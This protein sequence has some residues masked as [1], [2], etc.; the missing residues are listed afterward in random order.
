MPNENGNLVQIKNASP[1][2]SDAPK[3]MDVE[4]ARKK[5]DG[6]R[7]PR[8]WR[9]LEELSGDPSFNAMIE[10]EF[11]RYV[12]EWTDGVSRR[13][14]LKLSAASLAIAGLS[15]CT[16]QPEEAI[17]PYVQQPEELIPGKPMYFA[18]ARPSLF[19]AAPLLVRSN[20]YHPTNIQGNPD[21]PVSKGATDVF[22]IGS[23][24]DLYDP[25]RAQA[26]FYNGGLV[27]RKNQMPGE[28]AWGEVV[29]DIKEAVA[30][31]R[32]SGGAGIRFLT[33][34]VTSPSL[35]A[36]IRTVMQTLPQAKWYQ[37]EP[38][39]RDNARAGQQMAF[40]S[41]VEPQY[42]LQKADVI[43][44]LD[45]DFLSGPTFPGFHQLAREF[46]S[47][48]KIEAPE[49]ATM[50][51][52]YVVESQTTTTGGK[53]DH[54]L[55][56]KPSQVEQF[57]AALASRVGVSGVSGN[58]D[59][60]AAK[61]LDTLVKD[62]NESRGKCVV[63][64]G[65]QQ[66]PAVHALVH[67][68]NTALGAN[69]NTVLYGEPIEIV[70]T[71][72][73]AGLKELVADMNA[74]KVKAIVVIGG[75]PIFNAPTDLEFEKAYQKVPFRVAAMSHANST[76]RL[77]H[78]LVP[79]A[80]YLES[81]GDARA[82]DGSISLMQPLIE[83]LY[84][85]KTPYEIFA[86]F[87][88]NSGI[89]AYDTVRGHW[90][91]QAKGADFEKWWRKALHDGLISDSAPAP[92]NVSAKVSGLQLSAI[93][94]NAVEIAFR[95]DPS[96]LDGRYA[97]NGW[98]QELPKPVSK[99]TWDN[100]AY[101]SLNTAQHFPGGPLEN[102][103]VI[104]LK[105][106]NETVEAP[107]LIVPGMPD[108]TISVSLGYGQEYSGR[109]GQGTGFNPYVLRTSTNMSVSP[110]SVSRSSRD[111]W[112]LAL[113]QQQHLIDGR[114]KGA[115]KPE[116]ELG[117]SEA[118]EEA[119][120]RGI[121][122][123]A[124]LA[125]YKH[126][127]KIFIDG[128]H[129]AP[130]RD[131]TLY[132]ENGYSSWTEDP[133]KTSSLGPDAPGKGHQWG[134]AID[135]NSCV[136]CNSCVIA[137][138][139]ENNIPVV[140]KEQ[141]KKG[142]WMGWLR[143]DTYFE[144]QDSHVDVANPR[145]YFQPLP[146]MQCENAPCEPVCPVG[147]TTHSPEGLNNMVYN[148]CVGTRYCQNNCPYKVRRFNFL[149]FSDWDTESLYPMRNPD[150]TVRSR[151]VMEKCTYCVQ[152][153]TAGRIQAEKENRKIRDGEVRT[154]C[155]ESCPTEAIVFGDVSDP[156]SRVSQLKRQQRNYALLADINT[157]PRTT[158]LAAVRNPN[159]ALEPNKPEKSE[160][161]HAG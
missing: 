99:V 58:V 36:H 31:D 153:I 74:G 145:A 22:S 139:S 10:N 85:G 121:I 11:P 65:E 117:T 38:V 75:D 7:G 93:P 69:G 68:M 24:Y 161:A 40:G 81:W 55:P 43:V 39:N 120:E 140:G 87:T 122:R 110:V 92:R 123:A 34:T 159:E 76:S 3:P 142:R 101:M 14:F 149:L 53:A 116:G 71:N 52:L 23:L 126:N 33:E 156:N 49:S 124:S 51:R 150:V 25:D 95:P 77:S 42:Q 137:C 127:P 30:S 154:A 21:H 131:L 20:E 4:A 9:T 133:S 130:S 12:S 90:Q 32:G 100:A 15:A 107:V 109:V 94:A 158:Y 105:V 1:K 8:Y 70:P 96:I 35:A 152:R 147:A 29:N 104:T 132:G 134:M 128:E 79:L 64:P 57:A 141:V 114:R 73:T 89:T 26:V 138:Y 59:Q 2:A 160:G 157:R 148:R 146:C 84:G 46:A 78:W 135:M 41:Y 45:A 44:S 144:S 67:A 37:Y 88:E 125:E 136:G 151:G 106:G 56:L 18:T 155:Q 61:F 118:G 98:L 54:R 129:E 47:R 27:T 86:A 119:V 13:N 111:F 48:R 6:A 17:V 102:Q 113:T 28:R 97:N 83:P 115:F 91:T 66:S 82:Y 143:I 62:L 5:L 16:R 80:H 19:G 60:N 108:N 103:N 63:I 50:S 112:P 72:Q